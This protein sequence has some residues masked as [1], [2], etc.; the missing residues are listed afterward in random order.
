[1]SEENNKQIN[2]LMSFH[3]Q[4]L[5]DQ[6]Q[7]FAELIELQKDFLA[8]QKRDFDMRSKLFRVV[9]VLAVLYVALSLASIYLK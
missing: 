8:N 5:T 6:K 1:M 7:S 9:G 3:N 2:E 4:L